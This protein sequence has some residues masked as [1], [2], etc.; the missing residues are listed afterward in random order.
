MSV[1]VLALVGY[2]PR[3]G[4]V[5]HLLMLC[6]F[7]LTFLVHNVCFVVSAREGSAA[8]HVVW[9]LLPILSDNG[10]T[11]YWKLI[12]SDW[13]PIRWWLNNISLKHLHVVFLQYTY[14]LVPAQ[15]EWA[16][17]HVVCM[18]YVYVLP[19]LSEYR[20]RLVG[21]WFCLFDISF[22]DDPSFIYN[23]WYVVSCTI[24]T[25]HYI[26]E[27][28]C[29]IVQSLRKSNAFKFTF[30]KCNSSLEIISVWFIESV[31]S[32]LLPFAV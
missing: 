16:T 3:T 1:I 32:L 11:A 26:N 5:G 28:V 29:V 30:P 2:P 7:C 24:V 22:V 14:S 12:L 19:I 20:L 25:S 13:H 8:L 21:S 31:H 4:V 18:L 15:E 23:T 10:F 6:L 17:F 27:Y 9:I